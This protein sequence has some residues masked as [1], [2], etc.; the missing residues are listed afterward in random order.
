MRE[1]WDT[2][3]LG[4][5]K[6]LDTHVLALRS[7]LGARRDH[8]AAR[9]RLPLR[10]AREAPAR[11]RDRRRRGGRR[12][13]VRR[14]ARRSCSRRSYRDEELLRLQRDTVAAT[15]AI[16]VAPARG[17]PVE[18]PRSARPRS[19]S[20]TAPGGASP[21]S[22]PAAAPTRSCARRC[23]RARPPTAH[24]RR[25]A[26]RSPCRC[27]C[28]ERVTG[29]RAR[30]ALRRGRGARRAR[31]RGWRSPALAAGVIVA[32]PPCAALSLGA[33]ARRA[34][35]APRGRR[36]A[37]WATATSRARAP[38]AGR[39]RG[40]RG[41]RRA[42]RHR[43]SGSRSCRARARV[44]RRRLAP[45]AHAAGRRCGSS[46][47]RSSCA[48]R[49][50]AE[51]AAALAQVDRLQSDDRHAAR[52]RARRPAPRRRPPTSRSC[53][54]DAER[55]LAR[56]RWPP[57]ARPLRA[58][59]ST[60][61]ADAR[62]PSPR[63]VERDPRR[64]A[65]Q[66]RAPRRRRRS[67][68][69]VRELDGWLALDVADEGA[70]F[71]DDPEDAFARRAGDRDGHGIGLALARSLAHAEGGRLVVHRR[72]PRSGPHPPAAGPRRVGAEARR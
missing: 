21:G 45:A 7:K 32:R 70:G 65:R 63:V 18:L 67:R 42:R 8:D 17:D 26:R 34:A 29:A 31:A 51:L 59:A 23:A 44:Q 1:V 14:A 2:E 57:T 64:A 37:A 36:R 11:R 16:D 61:R 38:R 30:R 43:R 53:V 60:R 28:G 50:A 9:R 41:R 22:G 13:P 35:R 20:T 68:S 3:W 46:S 10:G 24:A 25:P 66:R 52:R 72:R 55:A 39:P 56:P 33:A 6:T 48:R 40:R 71:A 47:R 15:R 58:A 69:T 5:T 62:A 49:R 27:S 19:R 54:D 12:R 4:S